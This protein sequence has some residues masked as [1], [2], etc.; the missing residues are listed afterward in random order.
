MSDIIVRPLA[1]KDLP[2]ADRINRE[3]FGTFF[4]LENPMEFRGDGE[5]VPG[6]HR[7]NPDG[8][9]AAELDG[10][11]VA[12][13]FVMDWGDVGIFGPLT[14]DVRYWGR[15][16]ARA[17]MDA[18][19]AYMDAGGFKLQGLFTHPQSAKHIRLYEEYGFRMQHI[20]AVMDKQVAEN[21]KLP[22]DCRLFSELDDAQCDEAVRRCRE[23]ADSIHPGLD[24]GGEI[25]SIAENGYGDTLLIDGAGEVNGF[26]CCH[27]GA[28]SEAGSAQTL[29]KFACVSPGVAAPATFDRLVLSCEAYC[30]SRGVTR[31]VAG[32]NT[33][34]RECYEALLGAGFRTWMNGIAMLRPDGPGYNRPG[35]FVI[36][37]WR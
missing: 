15:G 35:N 21:A 37:D 31:L 2:A 17:M 20:T 12:C 4:G 9:F 36:D 11:L 7:L 23:I 10:D 6:R 24:L 13:G 19:M 18:M 1:L 32:T 26:A 34:R 29:V 14:V 16:I 22:G 27:Q 30:A 8:A 5:V 28:G 3:A 25:R 33:G